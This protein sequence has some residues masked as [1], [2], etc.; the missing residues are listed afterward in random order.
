RQADRTPAGYRQFG[1]DDV[2]RMRF[3]QAAQRLGLELAE[4]RELLDIKEHGLCPCGHARSLL[5]TKL[6][7][8]EAQLDALA[9]MRDTIRGL[10]D[11]EAQTG[12][13]FSCPPQLLQ[14]THGSNGGH[15]G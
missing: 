9:G 2:E 13:C 5:T 3:I 6:V 7:E 1:E 8:I 12:R 11:T 4:I 14:I 10:L 15:D